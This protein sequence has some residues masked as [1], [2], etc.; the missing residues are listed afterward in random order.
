M[1]KEA[2]ASIRVGRV[3]G[4]GVGANV[5]SCII[6]LITNDEISLN[7]KNLL[8]RCMA[9]QW[10]VASWLGSQEANHLSFH[11]INVNN[12]DRDSRCWMGLP[13][14]I[15]KTNRRFS[16]FGET[17]VTSIGTVRP[18]L[19]ICILRTRSIIRLRA[20]VNSQVLTLPRFAS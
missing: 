5:I 19:V 14:Q 8:H 18:G 9:M 1:E 11:L 3:A 10:I 15:L 20:S 16:A 13:V 12:C 17:P 7:H 2:A 6:D 4:T